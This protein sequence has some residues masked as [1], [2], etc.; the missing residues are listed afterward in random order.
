VPNSVT[1]LIR[2][3]YLSGIWLN[4]APRTDTIRHLFKRDWST[5]SKYDIHSRFNNQHNGE[6]LYD[7]LMS[8]RIFTLMMNKIFI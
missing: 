1:Y 5:C 7:H 4:V 6:D 2:H 8:T 3:L